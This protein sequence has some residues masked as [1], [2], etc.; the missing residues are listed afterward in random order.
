MFDFHTHSMFS[1]DSRA[2]LHFM[3]EKAIALGLDGIAATDH[4]D[5]DFSNPNYVYIP[6]FQRYHQALL[7]AEARYSDK[8]MLAKGL[9]LGIQHGDTLDKCR[10][11]VT[12]FR[13]DFILGSFH[14]AEGHDISERGFYEG[15]SVEEAYRAFYAYM[16]TCLQEYDDYDVIAHFNIIDR[17]SPVIPN[18]D[19]YFDIVRKILTLLVE[20]GKGIEI[21][22][23]SKR[24][25]MGGLCTPT[26]EI[27]KLYVDLG[28]EIVTTGS[29]A[30][31][32]EDLGAELA[33]AEEMIRMAGLGR[34]SV[35]KDRRVSHIEI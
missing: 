10:A 6:D 22:T 26:F 12:A 13:Y 19:A 27:L 24:Y 9:E 1:S 25:G 3:V 32:P 21:N 2:P 34:V 31:R 30:H 23:S 11:A 29:D 15:R 16:L 14:C 35:F 8:I 18:N 33:S 4:Y 7:D 28:G 20:R 5:P 17:Y